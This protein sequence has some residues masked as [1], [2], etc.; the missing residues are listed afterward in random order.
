MNTFDFNSTRE[1]PE[2][3]TKFFKMEKMSNEDLNLSDTKASNPH[4]PCPYVREENI[5]SPTGLKESPEVRR[6]SGS[7]DKSPPRPRQTPPPHVILNEIDQSLWINLDG[8]WRFQV[9]S[10]LK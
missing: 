1:F 2:P 3:S 5:K 7:P 6:H 8:G 9:K 10:N 4:E